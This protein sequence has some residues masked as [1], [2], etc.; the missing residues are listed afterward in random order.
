MICTRFHSDHYLVGEMLVALDFCRVG[1]KLANKQLLDVV[2]S[3]C[4]VS[5]YEPQ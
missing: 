1:L 3:G 4:A 2:R 5:S